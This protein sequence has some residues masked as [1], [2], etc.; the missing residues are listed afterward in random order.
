MI[1]KFYFEEYFLNNLWDKFYFLCFLII[2]YFLF[3]YVL[4]SFG[5]YNDMI[6]YEVIWIRIWD[7]K[8]IILLYVIENNKYFC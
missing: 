4:N 8:I 3:M 2:E 7:L 5:K 6:K 1:L